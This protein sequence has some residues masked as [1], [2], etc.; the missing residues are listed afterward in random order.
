ML[1]SLLGTCPSPRLSVG[2]RYAAVVCWTLGS[3]RDSRT[4]VRRGRRRRPRT[5]WSRA[6]AR[7]GLLGLAVARAPAGDRLVARAAGPGYSRRQRIHRGTHRR[8]RRARRRVRVTDGLG[9]KHGE[10]GG[11]MISGTARR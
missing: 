10:L 6:T 2:I 4:P 3:V 7:L 8:G 5:R 1:V 9:P 11:E